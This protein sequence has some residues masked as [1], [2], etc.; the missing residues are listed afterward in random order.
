VSAWLSPAVSATQ[1]PTQHLGKLNT[2]GD[3]V[4]RKVLSALVVMPMADALKYTQA[5]SLY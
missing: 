4:K 3:P 2:K 5:E 1:K